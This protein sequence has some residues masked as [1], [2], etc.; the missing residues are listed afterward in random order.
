VI[1]LSPLVQLALL[2]TLALVAATQVR[3]WID[4]GGGTILTPGKREQKIFVIGPK[5]GSVEELQ[6]LLNGGWRVTQMANAGAVNQVSPITRY[7]VLLE[8][9]TTKEQDFTFFTAGENQQAQ[10]DRM[11]AL[12]KQG[13]R[14]TNITSSSAPGGGGSAFL[15][16]FVLEQ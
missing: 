1:R 6:S 11:S 4:P 5:A 12:M 7:S 2:V 14:I 15:T 8:N 10:L 3:S 9:G 13:W 16:V